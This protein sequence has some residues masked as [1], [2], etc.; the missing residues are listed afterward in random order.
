MTAENKYKSLVGEIIKISQPIP[1][2]A[3]S[4]APAATAPPSGSRVPGAAPQGTPAAAIPVS[5]RGDVMA[6]QNLLLDFVKSGVIPPTGIPDAK[7]ANGAWGPK[8]NAALQQVISYAQDTLLMI[9]ELR[10]EGVNVSSDEYNLKYLDALK[11]F[12]PA[13]RGGRTDLT[14][15]EQSNWARTIEKHLRGIK[16][17]NQ[18]FNTQIGNKG[19]F[20]SLKDKP[21]DQ[22]SNARQ[23]GQ[24]DAEEST[25]I[26]QYIKTNTSVPISIPGI[27]NSMPFIA[28][29]DKKHYLNWINSVYK[30]P[31]DEKQ[32]A[33]L[34]TRVILPQL[35]QSQK[36]TV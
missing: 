21:L 13:L 9:N 20:R 10:N 28:L 11:T 25:K 19:Q 31:I 35:S 30:T 7:F 24:I 23:L 6:M 12:V 27:A 3:P 36:G 14:P 1:G 4:K 15:E 2:A 16:A 5:A 17:L 33:D 29:T 34:F 32:A 8:T 26:D 18:S 22:Y